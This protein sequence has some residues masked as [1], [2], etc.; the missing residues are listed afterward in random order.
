MAWGSKGHQVIALIAE[1]NLTPAARAEVDR[2]LAL[3]PGET[4]ASISTWADEHRSP[5]TA[6]WHYVNFPKEDCIYQPER[7]CPDGRCVVA[8]IDKVASV[9]ASNAAD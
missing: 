9:F 2:L 3:E 1:K 5:Q 6:P 4:L 7:D 8:A